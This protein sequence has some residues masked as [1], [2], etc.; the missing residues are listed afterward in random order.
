[1]PVSGR[2]VGWH[3]SARRPTPLGKGSLCSAA[4]VLQPSNHALLI[5]SVK[6]HK[7]SGQTIPGSPND[8]FKTVFKGYRSAEGRRRGFGRHAAA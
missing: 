3:C 6:K 4:D 1:M 2:A 7:P 8:L 5:F